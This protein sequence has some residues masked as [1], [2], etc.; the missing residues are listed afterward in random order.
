MNPDPL[1]PPQGVEHVGDRLQYRCACC[2]TF[3]DREIGG[4]PWN[5]P[6]CGHLRR[7]IEAYADTVAAIREVAE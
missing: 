2:R 7:D 1:T 6:E 5:C 3:V 4:C